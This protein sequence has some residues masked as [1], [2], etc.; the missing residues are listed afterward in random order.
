M[1]VVLAFDKFKG[2][3][4]AHRLNDAA[5]QALTRELA[6]DVV[7]VPVADGGDGTTGVLASTRPG[8]W[9]TTPTMGPLLRLDPVMASY[10]LCDDG[11][12]LLEVAA[13]SGLALLPP[14]QRDVMQATTLGTGLLM[15]NAMERGCQ[16]IVLG[17]GGSATCDAAMG[18][19]CALGAEFLDA[20]G[21]YL[22]PNASS[23]DRITYIESRGI[24]Q[25]VYDCRITLLTDVDT[26]LCG[27]RGA[28]RVFGPQK[29]A[30]PAQVEQLERGLEH[31]ARLVGHD[32][33][34]RP[35]CGA[36]GGI[37]A[38]MMHQL[39]CQLVPGA[40]YVLEHNGFHD[41][42]NGADLIIT[43][44]GRLDRQTFMGKGPG[45]VIGMARERQIPVAAVCGTIDPALD[46]RETGLS[47]AVAVSEGLSHDD[48]MDAKSTL[49]R[50]SDAV[51]Q[52]VKQAVT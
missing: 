51:V 43:G 45:V 12:A 46:Y 49:A 42:M 30:T 39:D 38:L 5:S 9:V 2:T 6:A 10:Y 14:H 35:G 52:I 4:T 21:H 32:I 18:I 36:A 7:C 11:T 29:G 22:P 48:A 20:D 8:R 16:S 17:L 19:M 31:I 25:A 23:L 41:A 34:D 27:E 26:P 33:A 24:P 44:E 3:V 15:R 13:A 1:K 47:R 50:V 37:P 40:P 28:A